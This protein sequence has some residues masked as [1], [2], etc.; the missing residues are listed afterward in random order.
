M[1]GDHIDVVS[2]KNIKINVGLLFIIIKKYIFLQYTQTYE[3]FDMEK[4]LITIWF[5]LR[6]ILTTVDSVWVHYVETVVD[7]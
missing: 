5:G 3:G 6:A 1:T 2:E 4:S 7:E